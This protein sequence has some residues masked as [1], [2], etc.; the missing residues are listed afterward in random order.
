[1]NDDAI[2]TISVLTDREREIAAMTAKGLTAI[3][4]GAKLNLSQHTI[5]THL[6]N[7]FRKLDIKNGRQLTV[8]FVL[9]GLVTDWRQ[10]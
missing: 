9:A 6:Y 2:N 7:V 4:V 10:A 8:V 1:M 5:K 3:D